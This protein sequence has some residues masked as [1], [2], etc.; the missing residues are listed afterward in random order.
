MAEKEGPSIRWVSVFSCT[1]NSRL[2]NLAEKLMS[3]G[4]II[5]RLGSPMSPV[6]LQLP[7]QIGMA[8]NRKRDIHDVYGG[9]RQR[10]I[11]TPNDVPFYFLFTGQSG[12]QYG[13]DDGWDEEGSDGGS[14][15]SPEVS[16]FLCA[17]FD[18][19]RLSNVQNQG[20]TRLQSNPRQG[21]HH[22]PTRKVARKH[23][24]LMDSGLHLRIQ[25]QRCNNRHPQLETPL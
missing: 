15:D 1:G 2:H 24:C 19:L 12:S 9:Q 4:E 21:P 13:Y 14:H 5:D 3:D 11:S 17:I 10:D 18:L 20:R 25:E 16:L 8:Y 6:D 23:Y 22:F 7:F